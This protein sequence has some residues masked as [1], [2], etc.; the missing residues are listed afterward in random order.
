MLSIEIL[1]SR[2]AAYAAA[3]CTKGNLE[4]LRTFRLTLWQ[5]WPGFPLNIG[6]MHSEIR[7]RLI[8]SIER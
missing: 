2:I 7:C 4:S 8:P 6:A 5:D 3:G 1:C